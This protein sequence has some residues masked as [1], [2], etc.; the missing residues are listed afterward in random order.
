M[1]FD[2]RKLALLISSAQGSRSMNA[3]AREADVAVSY[4]SRLLRGKIDSPPS[5]QFLKKIADVSVGDIT[6]TDLMQ[7]AG[8]LSE[9]EIN[10]LQNNDSQDINWK[11]RALIAE[12]ENNEL[13]RTL[14]MIQNFCERHIAE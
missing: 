7:A 5:A 4:I 3:L 9:A 2:P 10:E 11:E 12:A 14:K 13:K 8:H 1:V 6:Y